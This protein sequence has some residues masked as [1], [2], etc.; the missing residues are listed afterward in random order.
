MLC[1]SSKID[2]TFALTKKI[3]QINQKISKQ[4]RCNF[5]VVFQ[6]KPPI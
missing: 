3:N 5:A 4:K 1:N 2:Y 6:I